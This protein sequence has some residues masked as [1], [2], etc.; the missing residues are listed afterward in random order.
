MELIL[1]FSTLS[2]S[3]LKPDLQVERER[4][5]KKKNHIKLSDSKHLNI[6]NYSCAIKKSSI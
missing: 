3:I 2:S 1:L 4:E 5:G 6:L